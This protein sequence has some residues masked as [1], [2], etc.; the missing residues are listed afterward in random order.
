MLLENNVKPCSHSR[1][2]KVA[3]WLCWC[4]GA[5]T[6]AKQKAKPKSPQ[7]VLYK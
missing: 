2:Q 5:A 3:Q 7:A 4:A 1:Q 6:A